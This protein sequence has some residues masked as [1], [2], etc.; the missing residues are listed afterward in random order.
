MGAWER[1]RKEHTRCSF[2]QFKYT[3]ASRR[4]RVPIKRRFYSELRTPNSELPTPKST[5]PIQHKQRDRLIHL[6][7]AASGYTSPPVRS[8]TENQS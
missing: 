5:I 1:G 7:F 2:H 6:R 3:S 4:S 8:D